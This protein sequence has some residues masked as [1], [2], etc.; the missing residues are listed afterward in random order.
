[1]YIVVIQT[2]SSCMIIFRDTLPE[3]KQTNDVNGP[4]VSQE[5]KQNTQPPNALEDDN[6]TIM[7]NGTDIGH[8]CAGKLIDVHIT[9]LFDHIRYSEEAVS[10]LPNRSWAIHCTDLP[11][12][13]IVVSEMV[14]Q[15]FHG[16]GLEPFY[17]KQVLKKFFFLIVEILL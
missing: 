2:I 9:R 11:M 5:N 3:N 17:T 16:R 1:M 4:S 6:D 10:V 7:N 12:K 14:M 8:D 13:R 15:N